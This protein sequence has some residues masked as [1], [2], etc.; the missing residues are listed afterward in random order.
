MGDRMKLQAAERYIGSLRQTISGTV[1]ATPPRIL[2]LLFGIGGVG[3]RV[4]DHCCWTAHPARPV[5][6]GA[7][8]RHS[9]MVVPCEGGVGDGNQRERSSIH[10]AQQHNPRREAGN[11][12]A[13]V[14]HNADVSLRLPQLHPSAQRIP[15]DAV[16]PLIFAPFHPSHQL[17]S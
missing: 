17:Q 4:C 11:V 5:S 3:R 10:I 8:L 14:W 13:I 2:P 12:A 6:L 9:E 1:P 16:S 7:T 15:P